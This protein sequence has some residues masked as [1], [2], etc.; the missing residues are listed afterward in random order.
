MGHPPSPVPIRYPAETP[1]PSQGPGKA[2]S[3]GCQSR[4]VIGGDPGVGAGR[5]GS[6]CSLSPLN[7]FSFSLPVL[8][9]LQQTF[10]IRARLLR[11][12]L[13]PAVAETAMAPDLVPLSQGRTI[14][15]I[16]SPGRAEPG[17]G[18]AASATPA[19][20]G[21]D[22]CLLW[23]WPFDWVLPLNA[24]G[25]LTQGPGA[26]G[27]PGGRSRGGDD[28]SPLDDHRKLQGMS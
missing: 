28:L 7:C 19:R 4:A 21:P 6:P 5:K 11:W 14:G 17:A 2:G 22:P 13:G 27:P 26:V 24:R 9:P 15:N 12:A 16:S 3:G 23:R 20:S 8:H 10:A 18:G 1:A 25:G